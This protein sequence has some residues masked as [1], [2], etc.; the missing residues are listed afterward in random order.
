MAGTPV[1]SSYLIQARGTGKRAGDYMKNIRIMFL[2][3][4]LVLVA[5]TVAE[6]APGQIKI[7]TV[8]IQEVLAESK[9]GK[10]AQ[11]KLQAKVD[12]YQGKLQKEQQEAD[13]LRQE[14]EKKGSVWS[15]AVRSEKERDYQ[16]RMRELQVKSEDARFELQQLEKQIMEPILKELHAILADHGKKNGYTL[17]LENTRKGLLSRNGL[18]YVDQALDISEQVKKELDSKSGK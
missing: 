6:A 2:A 1:L 15:E 12:E 5:M 14:I 9:A 4:F 8:S 3:M 16:K 11:Q 17:I 7:A 18:L 13:S 10:Q